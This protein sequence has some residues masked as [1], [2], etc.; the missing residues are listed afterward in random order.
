MKESVIVCY[1]I[2]VLDK[3]QIVQKGSHDELYAENG[4]YRDMFRA[5]SQWYREKER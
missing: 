2:I 5:Q 3:G 1:Q 4:L